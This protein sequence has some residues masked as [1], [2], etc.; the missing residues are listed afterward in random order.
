MS[1][2]AVGIPTFEALVE[3]QK[4]G[5]QP[6]AC[7]PAG[8]ALITVVQESFPGI[9]LKA[10]F[11]ENGDQLFD[12]FDDETCEIYITDRPL[13]VHFVLEQSLQN[14]C[15]AN[16]KFIGVIG[17]PMDF[18]LS[19]YAIGIRRDIGRKVT[20]TLSYW[21]N[22]LMSCNPL[23]PHGPCADGNLATFFEGTGG[24]GDECG[25]VLYP[26]VD[27]LSGLVITGIVVA[28]VMV[29]IGVGIVWHRYR[30]ARQRQQCAIQNQ[31]AFAQAEKERELN[32]VCF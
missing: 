14:R 12:L 28:A 11:V 7:A 24:T 17:D 27:S 26:P 16:G 15:R 8:T 25:Y 10:V 3:L 30:L 6:A 1:G 5:L 31:V 20:D 9:Q 29:V 13:A 23:D 2:T 32:E 18:G 4:A 21:M 19:H 22:V